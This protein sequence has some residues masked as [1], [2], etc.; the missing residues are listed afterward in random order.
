VAGR[1]SLD[2]TLESFKG[3]EIG[4]N[5]SML[6]D[7]PSQYWSRRFESCSGRSNVEGL[8]PIKAKDE[9]GGERR[10]TTLN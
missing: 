7:S 2:G 6:Y 10:V 4:R 3:V 5:L 8:L 1:I 9:R